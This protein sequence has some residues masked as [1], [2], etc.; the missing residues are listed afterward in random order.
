MGVGVGVAQGGERAA[1]WRAAALGD[2]KELPALLQKGAK[3][4]DALKGWGGSCPSVRAVRSI[5]CLLAALFPPHAP[6][7][8]TY[9][10]ANYKCV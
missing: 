6:F 5:G 10:E 2:L 1:I 9:F 3:A 4:Q 7:Q 8:A